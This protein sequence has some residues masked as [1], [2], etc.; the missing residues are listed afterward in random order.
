MLFTYTVLVFDPKR[1]ITPVTGTYGYYYSYLPYNRTY[2][3]RLITPVTGTIVTIR[4]YSY[5][6]YNKSQCTLSINFTSLRN[7][8]TTNQT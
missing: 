6:P 2:P 1:L 3:K 8:E 4:P 7:I 5:L